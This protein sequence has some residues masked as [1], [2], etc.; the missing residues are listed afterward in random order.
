MWY[1][2]VQCESGGFYVDGPRCVIVEADNAEEADALAEKE[3]VY[4]DGAKTGRDCSCCGDRWERADDSE[5]VMVTS[6]YSADT[7]EELNTWGGIG[8]VSLEEGI[9]V[10]R[11][12]FF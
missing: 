3:G 2:Y 12:V 11:V 4:F 8:S 9:S 1:K 6:T 10:S 5:I 7:L